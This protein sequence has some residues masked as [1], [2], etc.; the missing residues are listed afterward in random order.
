MEDYRKYLSYDNGHG[1]L[2]NTYD[3]EIL[4]KYQ[5]NYKECSNIKSIIIQINNFIDDNYYEELDDLELVLEHLEEN[6]YYNEVNK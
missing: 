6:Y 1:I 4:D 3:K 2:I 5:I